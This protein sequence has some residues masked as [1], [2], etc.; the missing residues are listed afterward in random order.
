[1]EAIAIPQGKNAG[2]DL[3]TGGKMNV[4]IAVIIPIAIS[5]VAGYILYQFFSKDNPILYWVLGLL[6]GGIAVLMY[7]L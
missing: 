7:F 4:L 6:G 3:C 1:M 5:A 2:I